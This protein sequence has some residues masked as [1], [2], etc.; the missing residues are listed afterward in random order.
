[1]LRAFRPG[2]AAGRG[3]APGRVFIVGA[4]PGNPDLLTLRALQLLGQADVILHD[5]LVPQ[6]ILDLARRDADRVYVGKAPG[7]HHRSQREIERLMV[8]EARAGRTVV[9]LKG[10]D[11]FIFGRGGEEV[12]ALR[13]AGIEYEVVPGITA[14]T[15]CAALAGIPL[16]HRDLAQSLT[17]VTGHVATGAA[18]LSAA[19]GSEA[20]AGVDWAR[21]AGPGRTVAV[22]MGVKQAARIRGELLRAGLAR[23]F[24]AALVVDGSREGQQVLTGTIGQLPELA[25]AAPAG[26]PGLLIIGQVAALGSNLCGL[27]EPAAVAA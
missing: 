1:A 6:A 24:P 3:P 16:T 17:L 7:A 13:A 11:P 5:H 18:A 26:R 20:V 27:N 23:D 8:S 15:A 9:R 19:G 10:G 22:Y 21:L 4:G 25:A 14:A 12:Q 2:R